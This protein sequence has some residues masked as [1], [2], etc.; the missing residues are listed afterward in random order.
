MSLNADKIMADLHAA[1]KP[2]LEARAKEL[3]VNFLKQIEEFTDQTRVHKLDDLLKKAADYEVQ[4]VLQSDPDKAR[5]YAEAAED[6]LRQVKL[7]VIS[8][9]IVASREVAAMLQAGALAVWEG[10]K[11]V[12]GGLLGVVVKSAI[13][14]LLGPAGGAIAATAGEFL[15]EAVDG[16]VGDDAGSD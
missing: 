14:S 1:A 3:R 4:A 11:S 6:V 16:V 12:A 7:V 10:F 5:Q 8:E 13:T 9:Q 15:G 2:E